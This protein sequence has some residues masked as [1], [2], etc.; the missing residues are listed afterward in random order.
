MILIDVVAPFKVNNPD[1]VKEFEPPVPSI[2]IFPARPEP[3]DLEDI[4]DPFD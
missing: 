4:V 1:K 2:E 3:F